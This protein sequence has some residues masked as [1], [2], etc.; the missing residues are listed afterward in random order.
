MREGRRKKGEVDVERVGEREVEVK[1]M[2]EDNVLGRTDKLTE[3]GMNFHYV[4]KELESIVN[5]KLEYELIEVVDTDR[6]RTEVKGEPFHIVKIKLGEGGERLSDKEIEDI[7]S[8]ALG[9][10][11]KRMVDKKIGY[12]PF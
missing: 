10:Y 8:W 1:F 9:E 5:E 6:G 7:M 3:K 11:G 2:P 12:L 4:Y